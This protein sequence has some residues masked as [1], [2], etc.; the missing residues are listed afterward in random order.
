MVPWVMTLTT[1]PCV[2]PTSAVKT[3]VLTF[4]SAIASTEGRIARPAPLRGSRTNHA[5]HDARHQQSYTSLTHRGLLEL[6]LLPRPP[7]STLRRRLETAAHYGATSAKKSDE[8]RQST[9]GVRAALVSTSPTNDFF[10]R[11]RHQWPEALQP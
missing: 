1:A 3:F 4:T 10:D 2:R 7:D 11:Q 6:D 8:L 5:K 9:R